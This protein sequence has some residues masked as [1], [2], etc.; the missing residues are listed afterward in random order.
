MD[1]QGEYNICAGTGTPF[2][3]DFDDKMTG[4]WNDTSTPLS[5]NSNTFHEDPAGYAG[6]GFD[7]YLLEEDRAAVSTA[8]PLYFPSLEIEED[9]TS[10]S[11]VDYTVQYLLP[12][13]KDTQSALQT[14]VATPP[15][16]PLASR[17]RYRQTNFTSDHFGLTAAAIS[18]LAGKSSPARDTNTQL[19]I[20][21]PYT[22]G[23]RSQ[24]TFSSSMQPSTQ[25]VYPQQILPL[26]TEPFD[27]ER[28]HSQ[29][30]ESVPKPKSDCPSPSGS[31]KCEYPGCRFT[32]TKRDE[33]RH[34]LRYHL[35]MVDRPYPCPQCHQRFLYPREVERHLSTHGLGRC[36][37]CP[38]LRCVRAVRGFGRQDH[39]QRH[40]R[41]KH[42]ANP[43]EQ[44]SSMTIGSQAG[45]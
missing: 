27:V 40:M 10:P 17:S 1:Y 19:W 20:P 11:P 35:P 26:P 45:L 3:N 4:I 8:S 24:H 2:G 44:D 15:E 38:I 7:D 23:D 16:S 28:S 18:Q 39:L 9:N 41:K 13:A 21:Q 32:Y 22:V 43:I 37:C 5:S 29:P 34:H 25:Q 36:H 12:Y 14:Q 30:N 33:L 6:L 42:G 31:L